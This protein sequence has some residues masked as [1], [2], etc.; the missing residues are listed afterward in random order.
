MTF[1]GKAAYGF[2]GLVV[3]LGACGQGAEEPPESPRPTISLRGGVRGELGEAQK[4]ERER[5]EQER[6]LLEGSSSP[7]A[8]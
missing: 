1:K 5:R 2:A 7:E 6:G 4:A 8:P 3:C